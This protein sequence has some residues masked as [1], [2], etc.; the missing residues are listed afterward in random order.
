MFRL[1]EGTLYPILHTLEKEKLVRLIE[2][3]EK[4]TGKAEKEFADSVLEVSIGAN[5]Q[6]IEELMG[7]G[8]MCQALLEIMEPHL[9]RRE[10]EGLEEGIKEGIP[11]GSLSFPSI[12]YLFSEK[13]N[14]TPF[15]S[16]I[17]IYHILL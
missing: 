9:Q 5:V 4:L 6:V 3:T 14:Q 12:L 1:K 15:A 7:D 10:K 16:L 17:T 11:M 8:R 2:S 13:P